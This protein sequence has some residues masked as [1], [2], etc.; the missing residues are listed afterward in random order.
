MPTSSFD[1]SIVITEED[2]IE[3]LVNSLLHDKPRVIEDKYLTPKSEERGKK[4][5]RV[6]MEKR[7]KENEEMENK[8]K[9][10]KSIKDELVIELGD[11]LLMDYPVMEKLIESTAIY[12]VLLQT[13]LKED[14]DIGPA[15]ALIH[16]ELK[17][18]HKI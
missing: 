5:L 1:K 10:I 8:E 3:R 16:G 4:I 18:T 2:A 7:R 12:A 6:F 17:E 13:G 14:M 9:I 15:V 11:K